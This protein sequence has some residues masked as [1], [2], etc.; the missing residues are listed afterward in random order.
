MPFVA[1]IAIVLLLCSSYPLACLA[2]EPSPAGEANPPAADEAPETPV[3]E[4]TAE[5]ALPGHSMHGEAFNEGPRQQALLLDGMGSIQF[6]VT[7]SKPEVQQFINQGVAQLH[8]FW[9]FESERSFRHAATL[10]PDC[11]MAYWGMAMS[12]MANRKRA[13]EFIEEAH[14]RKDSATA[15]EQKYIEALHAYLNAPNNK[16]KERAEAYISALEKIL[17]EWPDDIEAKAFLAHQIWNSRSD[18]VKVQ[19]YLAVDALLNQIYA[20]A[21]DHPAHHYTIHLWDYEKPERALASAAACGPS[22][23]GIAHMWHMPGHI[24]SRLKRY[25]DACWQQEASARVDHAHMMRF[26]ILPDQ[27]HNFAHNNEWLIR[28]LNHVGRV[29]DALALAKNM[30]SLPHHPKY[31]LDSRNNCSASFGRARLLETL[32][33]YEMWDT[34]IALA[35]TPYLEPTDVEREQ[36]RRLR[37][38]G[39]AYFQVGRAHD[40]Q[41]TLA[42]I[43]TWLEK[44]Q[45]ER[46]AAAQEAIAKATAEG[47]EQKQIDEAAEKAKK[48][49]AELVTELE[50]ALA[51]LEAYDAASHGDLASCLERLGKA[52]KMDAVM[53]ARYRHQAGQTD[54]A[55]EELKK[56]VSSSENEVQPLAGLVDLLWQAGRRDEA[57]AEFER[58]R[59]I[60][61]EIDLASGSPVFERLAPLAAELGYAV[62]W[63]QP[64]AEPTDLGPRPP[65]DSL[66]PFRWEP[67]SA[68]GWTLLGAHGNAMALKQYQGQWVVVIF[69]LGY[70]CLHCAEQLHAFAPMTQQFADA[71]ISLAAI[72]SDDQKGLANSLENYKDGVF[73]FPLLANEDL[74][75][76]R[77]YRAYDD[78]EQQPLHG[79]FLI[80]AEGR[81]RWHD[82][83]YEPFMDPQFVLRE[84]RRQQALD[85]Q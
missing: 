80:D 32:T 62:D 53:L 24:Y 54:K 15:R 58:L 8:G 6:P 83:S 82:I 79:T 40:G 20:V 26:G 37:H 46:D 66:G 73:P 19:S 70:G 43:K 48:S 64:A 29:S 47:K 61:S 31:N 34:L 56:K 7:T 38:L 65:L 78:F 50:Q 33:M 41:Q 5:G 4:N 25:R 44:K 2:Q 75:V 36:V 69:Y 28:N 85:E 11:A 23:P 74:S 12:N 39:R 52:G 13:K 63:R 55:I 59:A 67:S 49:F 3:S 27:I 51:E 10:D 21:P 9:Y 1:R 57:R 81:I 16:K 77:A 30:V 71:G 17:Y 84:A 72:S 18:G 42:E 35:D 76:F 14:K 45:A 60:S 68:P 22:L